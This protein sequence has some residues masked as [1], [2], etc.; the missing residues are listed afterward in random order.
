M[1]HKHK[2][3]IFVILAF[4][5]MILASFA[6][7]VTGASTQELSPPITQIVAVTQVISVTQIVPITQVIPVTAVSSNFEI[8]PIPKIILQRLEVSFLGQDG[9]KAIGSGCPGS[10]GK[11]KIID[12]HLTVSNI[13][14][15]KKIQRIVVTGDNST[16][17]WE[18]PCS[19]DWALLVENSKGGNLEIFIAPSQ[20]SKVYTVVIF[21]G[22]NTFALGNTIAP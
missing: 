7:K 13:D 16:L 3:Y 19:D 17:T 10:D 21:Y 1:Q 9:H 2:K 20:S 11:G 5:L 15:D 22:D 18:L 12:Y 6:C 14:E 4:S 8:P